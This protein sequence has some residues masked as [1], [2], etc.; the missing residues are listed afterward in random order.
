MSC[1][2]GLRQ[3]VMIGMSLLC[4]PA[5]LI[6]DEPTTALDVTVQA[7]IIE[8]LR[9]LRLELGMA[10]VLISHDFGVVAQLADRVLVMYAGRIVESAAAAQI[11]QRPRASLHGAAAA[12][13]AGLARAAIGAHCRAF[14]ASRRARRMSNRDVPLRRVASVPAARCTTQRPLLREVHAAQLTACHFPLSA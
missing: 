9:A 4:D 7:Q 12:L 5:L 11:L 13:R 10:I 6:A 14:L 2:E 3:R 8:L 1:R